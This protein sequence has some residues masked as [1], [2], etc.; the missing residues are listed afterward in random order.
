MS[1]L[2]KNAMKCLCSGEQ[3]QVDE[4]VRSSESLAT[5]ECSAIRYSCQ[6]G[7]TDQRVDTGNIEEAESS[8]REGLCLNYEEAR[9]LLG[10]L[11]YQRGNVEAAL[12]VFDG[13]DLA[14]VG[15]KIRTAITKRIERRKFHSNWDSGPMSIHAVSLLVEAVYLKARALQD[16]GR[17]K[18]A[19]QSCN[20][21]LDTLE[22]ALPDGSP[23]NI[24]DNKLQEI[25]CKA[26]E[27]L[28]E[29]W[30]LAGFSH[31][32]ISSYRR[33][34]LGHWN[35]D[36]DTMAKIQKEFAIFSSLWRLRCK[37]SKPSFSNGWCIYTQE[38][39]GRGNSSVNNS[40]EEV[41][42]QEN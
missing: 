24:T 35:L 23:G 8:L 27:L 42:S 33:A 26:V 6:N 1:S 11:E 17:F 9:A 20:I 25:V 10:R 37:P 21:V 22:S 4:M 28:P 7:E 18:E 14:S 40:I 41:C 31:E 2:L 15:P 39:Y 38:Q 5:K 36:A 30:K 13:I 3:L 19:A 34:L 32:A 12:R 29:L 16:L